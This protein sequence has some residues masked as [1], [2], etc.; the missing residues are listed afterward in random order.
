MLRI[1]VTG[2]QGF[3]GRKVVESFSQMPEIEVFALGR[4]PSTFL[5]HNVKYV[6]TDLSNHDDWTTVLPADIDVVLHLAQSTRYSQ[7]PDGAADMVRI[8]I[9][10]TATLIDWSR[11]HGVSRFILAS[12]GNVYESSA[13]VLDETMRCLPTSM[14]GAT[15]LSAEHLAW[16]YR[17]ILP[18]TIVRLFGVFGSGQTRGLFTNLLNNVRN[19]T[20]ITLKGGTGLQI[21]PIV[22]EDAAVA[23]VQ[24]AS[25]KSKG[26]FIFNLGGTDLTNV[27][28]ITT[29]MGELCN[30][31]PLFV[32][33][34]GVPDCLI[35]SSKKL[36]DY[37][38]W[39][40]T[41]SLRDGIHRMINPNAAR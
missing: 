39:R 21:T 28:E 13:L 12:T 15:K 14:Y 40:P 33:A 37:L 2:S 7:F 3:I 19:G 8:N 20:S 38:A 25:D 10:S 29:I 31:R 6:H 34:E 9:V 36:Y 1:L 27:R 32:V 30:R 24:L 26:S 4:R 11:K 18:V 22:V 5:T 41:I 16:A 35:A 17:D 23:L